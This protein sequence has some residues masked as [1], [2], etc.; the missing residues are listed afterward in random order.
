M[1]AQEV[2]T[3]YRNALS[4]D[5]NA[6][7]VAVR[8]YTG[9]GAARTSADKN[10]M[11]RVTDFRPDT[12]VGDIKQGDRSVILLVEDLV[13]AGFSLPVKITDKIVIRG[14]ECA[15]QALDDSTRRIGST[16]IA[17]EATVRG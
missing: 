15:I 5:G 14:R 11:A 17:I 3:D 7:T 13:T 9:T 1:N 6:E 2:A 4:A 12:L 16:L 10:A 8:R